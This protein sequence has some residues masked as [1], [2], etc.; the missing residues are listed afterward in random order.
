[1]YLLYRTDTCTLYIKQ[2]ARDDR[3]VLKKVIARFSS[4]VQNWKSHV[5]SPHTRP[6]PKQIQRWKRP[7]Y[8]GLILHQIEVI[9]S[10]SGTSTIIPF[11]NA[12]YRTNAPSY[13]LRTTH[14]FWP[15]KRMLKIHPFSFLDPTT[16]HISEN[17]HSW[18]I[19]TYHNFITFQ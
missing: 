13:F 18:F 9:Q 12:P 8:S 14:E 17:H 19:G 16:S 11:V 15:R 1:M 3:E 5:N 6:Y 10:K 4:L 7:I 2:L